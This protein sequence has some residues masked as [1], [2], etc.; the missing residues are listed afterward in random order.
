MRRIHA[1]MEDELLVIDGAERPRV[2]SPPEV[3]KPRRGAL[4]WI[5]QDG[6]LEGLL[7]YTS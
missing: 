5:F 4:V 7:V 2:E 6:R 1:A 3:S